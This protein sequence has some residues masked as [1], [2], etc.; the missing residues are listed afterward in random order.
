MAFEVLTTANMNTTVSGDVTPCSLV[1]RDWHFRRSCKSYSFLNTLGTGSTNLAFSVMWKHYTAA[2]RH[3]L[4]APAGWSHLVCLWYQ[5]RDL[6]FI[7]SQSEERA[8]VPFTA[9]LFIVSQQ[10]DMQCSISQAQNCH[11]A[12]TFLM[13]EGK[14]YYL[15][16]Y[17]MFLWYF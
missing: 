13:E 2:W 1:K 8:L 9:K 15:T 5:V 4:G 14:K 11:R 17:P 6:T 7:I 3:S 10:S 16:L 12:K